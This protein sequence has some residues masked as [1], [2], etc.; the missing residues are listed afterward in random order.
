[1]I[2]Q[3]IYVEPTERD[4]TVIWMDVELSMNI[5]KVCAITCDVLHLDDPF[6]PPAVRIRTHTSCHINKLKYSMP[7][8]KPRVKQTTR[9]KCHPKVLKI[10][11]RRDKGRLHETEPIENLSL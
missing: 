4:V 6:T 10:K 8:F 9:T 1:M 2:F 11:A 3:G 7:A 5:T